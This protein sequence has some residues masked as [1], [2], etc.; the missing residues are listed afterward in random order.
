MSSSF[1]GGCIGRG[2]DGVVVSPR[3][4]ARY[5]R[6]RHLVRMHNI[7]VRKKLAVSSRNLLPLY[8]SES[9]RQRRKRNPRAQKRQSPRMRCDAFSRAMNVSIPDR[10]KT[11]HTATS[12]HYGH[13]T[14]TQANPQKQAQPSPTSPTSNDTVCP[15]IANPAANASGH[16]IKLAGNV[17]FRLCNGTICGILN[18]C[19]ACAAL[20]GI[21]HPR[22]T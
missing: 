11:S 21:S 16:R 1:W 3:G 4:R 15:A 6:R 10:I 2:G 22:L 5:T 12:R 19:R 8:H 14:N 9:T 18:P 7:R 17:P 13:I 20:A